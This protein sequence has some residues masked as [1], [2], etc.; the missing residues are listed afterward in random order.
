MV[1]RVAFLAVVVALL[2]LVGG[3]SLT[4]FNLVKPRAAWRDA[5]ERACMATPGSL[6]TVT[7]TRLG[8]IKGQGSC[9]ILEPI[10]VSAL[11]GGGVTVSPNPT[12]GCPLASALDEWMTNA[13]QPAAIAW[14]GEPVVEIDQLDAYSCRPVD[15]IPSQNIS[16]HAFGNAIDIAG[17]ELADGRKITVKQDFL[18]GDPQS[19][20]FLHEIFAAACARFKTVLGPGY[21]EHDDH[22][23]LDLAHQNAE[24]TLRYCNP[25]PDVPAPQRAPYSTAPVATAPLFPALRYPAAVDP[26]STGSILTSVAH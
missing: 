2:A 6:A 17:Y 9:G 21:P 15:G 14:F 20:G 4:L 3:C 10:K 11:S 25:K 7:Y 8:R 24:G 26:K 18:R 19:K 13:V 16:E 5:E 1:R 12:I 22:F 23:H